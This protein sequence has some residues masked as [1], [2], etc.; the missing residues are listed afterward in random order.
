MRGTEDEYERSEA[1]GRYREGLEDI[2]KGLYIR[3]TNIFLS[4]GSTTDS[5]SNITESV[6]LWLLYPA[7]HDG[8]RD[9]QILAALAI[10]LSAKIIWSPL[11]NSVGD[12]DYHKC[13]AQDYLDSIAG[14]YSDGL[15]LLT[16]VR[17]AVAYRTIIGYVNIEGNTHLPD[18]VLERA[19]SVPGSRTRGRAITDNS[20]KTS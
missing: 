10:S 16:I 5:Q 17:S 4:N 14:R 7:V 15:P 1:S 2:T 12:F 6:R 3:K 20:A 18:R 11:S 8:S 9:S 13:A 19:D